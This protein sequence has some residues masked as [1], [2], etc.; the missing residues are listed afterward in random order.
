MVSAIQAKDVI[1]KWIEAANRKDVEAVMALY[2]ADPELESPVIVDLMNERSGRL[3]GTERVRAYITKAFALP[4]VSW[5][6][7]ESGWGVSSLTA[8]Y[9]NHKGTRSITYME[10]DSVGKIKRHVNHFIE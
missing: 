2:A 5:H 6:L 9:I 1:S 8:R 3:R 4:F 7:V 10:L